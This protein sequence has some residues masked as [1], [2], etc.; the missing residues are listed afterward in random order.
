M[1]RKVRTADKLDINSISSFH[2]VGCDYDKE[3]V[4]ALGVQWASF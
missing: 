4:K 2:R 1:Q 3:N